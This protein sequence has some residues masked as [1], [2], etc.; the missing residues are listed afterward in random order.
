MIFIVVSIIV[1]ILLYLLLPRVL[2][3]FSPEQPPSK[4]LLLLAC[5]LF[6]ISWYLPSPEIQGQQTA[7]TTHFVG[8]GIFSGLVW[9]YIKSYLRWQGSWLAEL[10]SLFA[11]VSTLGV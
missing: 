2:Q 9:L 3:K 5:L 4:A 11:L 1:P 7:A 8:G 6:F 10:L